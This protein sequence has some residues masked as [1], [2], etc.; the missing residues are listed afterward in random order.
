LQEAGQ[1]QRGLPAIKKARELLPNNGLLQILHAQLLLDVGG[2]SN[3]DEAQKLLVRAK[4]TESDSPIIYKL[5]AQA[6]GEKG[7]IARAELATAEYAFSTGDR[8]LAIEKARAALER[9]KSGTPEWL[10]AKDI[11]TFAEKK[12]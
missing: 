3:A 2:K 11:L 12:R 5:T 7:D 8:D 10:R 9:F 4:K 1:P 6:F